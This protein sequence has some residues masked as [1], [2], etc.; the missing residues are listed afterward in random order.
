MIKRIKAVWHK[1]S[2][3]LV[4]VVPVL[5]LVPLCWYCSRFPLPAPRVED[6]DTIT[7]TRSEFD[8]L[9]KSEYDRGIT[10]Q[11]SLIDGNTLK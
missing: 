6:G 11:D 1:Y 3:L 2:V 4:F 8:R 9:L 5:L 7:M 10:W